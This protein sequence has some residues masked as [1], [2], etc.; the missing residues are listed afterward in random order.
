[1][2]DINPNT[3]AW[4]PWTNGGTAEACDV[5][6]MAESWLADFGLGL[7]PDSSSK[8]DAWAKLDIDH[9]AFR[10]DSLGKSVAVLVDR[11]SVV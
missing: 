7:L 4:Q 6:G 2:K 8:P 11:K 5:L 9:F 3:I 10:L 1:M